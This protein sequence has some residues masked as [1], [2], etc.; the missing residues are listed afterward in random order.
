[1][2]WI[3]LRILMKNL[4][5]YKLYTSLRAANPLVRFLILV[6]ASLLSY[7]ASGQN[8]KQLVLADQYYDAGEYVTA[9]GLY[10]QYLNPGAKSKKTS[11]FPLNAKRSGLTAKYQTETDVLFRQAESYR[12]AHDFKKAAELYKQCFEKDQIKYSSA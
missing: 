5:S 10:G 9:A 3:K 12:L 1:M 11:G 4:F 7:Y 6:N 8:A 2:I